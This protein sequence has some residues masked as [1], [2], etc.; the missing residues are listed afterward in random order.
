[1]SFTASTTLSYPSANANAADYA[2]FYK[3]L[4]T[5]ASGLLHGERDWLANLA[6]LA[7]LLA[8]RLP[9]LNWCGFYLLRGGELVVGPFVG[10]PACV[11]IRLG[12]GVCGTTA[13]ERKSTLVPDVHAF[14]SHI[15]CDAASASELVVP[16]QLGPRLVGVLDLDSPR[17]NRFSE[18]D[19][20][21]L[22][23]IAVLLAESCDWPEGIGA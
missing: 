15:A 19:Q 18:A 11:R 12:R 7:A 20:T 23:R 5:E 8:M 9:E 2:A 16:I 13:V 22:E 6:N 4:H 14:P 21:G 10:K 1:M 17:K 3:D